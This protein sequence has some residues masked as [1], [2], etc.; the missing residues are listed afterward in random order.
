MLACCVVLFAL[1][2][3]D[4]LVQRLFAGRCVCTTVGFLKDHTH[5]TIWGE[6]KE[7]EINRTLIVVCVRRQ[8]L[9][10][11]FG[12]DSAVVR[13]RAPKRGLPQLGH[14][15]FY[16]INFEMFLSWNIRNVPHQK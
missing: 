7:R 2:L 3:L 9:L 13:H 12:L 4:G 5:L 15:H 1:L 14:L 6:L 8:P 16:T 11:D 10:M